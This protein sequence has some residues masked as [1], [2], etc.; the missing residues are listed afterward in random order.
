MTEETLRDL[1]DYV[2]ANDIR[3]GCCNRIATSCIYYQALRMIVDPT[4]IERKILDRR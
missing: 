3:C 1:G 2:A 4:P